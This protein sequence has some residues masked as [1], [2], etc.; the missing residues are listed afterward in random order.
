M[1]EYEEKCRHALN[2]FKMCPF[3]WGKIDRK[4]AED[5]LE[6]QPNGSYLLKDPEDEKKWLVELAIKVNSKFYF[7]RIRPSST[8]DTLTLSGLFGPSAGSLALLFSFETLPLK[9]RF[10]W[11]NYRLIDKFN[12]S[13]NTFMEI[14]KI[15]NEDFCDFEHPILRNKPFTLLELARNKISNTGIKDE[16]ISKLKIP[17]LLQNFLKIPVQEFIIMLE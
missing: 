15:N 14:L 17:K 16:D 7:C 12:Y 11:Q 5:I 3:Y 13:G 8:I 4:M 9:K 10:H 2:Q 6:D 1:S